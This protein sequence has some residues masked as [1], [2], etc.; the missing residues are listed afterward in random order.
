M[1]NCPDTSQGPTPYLTTPQDHR[2]AWL[3]LLLAASVEPVRSL[4]F[5][6]KVADDKGITLGAA[7]AARRSARSPGQI[8]LRGRVTALGRTAWD[9]QGESLEATSSASSLYSPAN[10]HSPDDKS[11]FHAPDIHIREVRPQP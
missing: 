8:H 11:S 2:R 10:P 7:T 6:D 4:A 1:L 9:R 5:Q 3:K